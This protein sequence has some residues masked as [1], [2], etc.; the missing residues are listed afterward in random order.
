NRPRSLQALQT[1]KDQVLLVGGL[2]DDSASQVKGAG[3]HS[4]SSGTFLNCVPFQAITDANVVAATTMDQL[5]AKEFS[6]ETQIGSLELGLESAAILGA[7]DGSSCAL[8]N[9]ISWSTATTPD[10]G[11]GAH[12]RSSGTFL[13][14]VPFQ[15]ITD[16]NV[17]AATTMDQ[18]VAK[19]FSRETQ[20]GS[21]EL[22]L[23]SA[24][25][26]GACDGSSCALT[27]TISWST[28]TT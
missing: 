15:A 13:N 4:R 19:E 14:C 16:A 9:T 28:A 17:V 11:A 21:L 6:R 8:T 27:N 25:I 24:A 1:L 18:L 5:V 3:A 23:E 10:L 26:L 7:C 20:I 12:S 2:A 22:G